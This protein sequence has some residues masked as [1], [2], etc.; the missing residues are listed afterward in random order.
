[1]IK[2]SRIA[3][4]QQVRVERYKDSPNHSHSLKESDM[5]KRPQA[6]RALVEHEAT[7]NYSP[8]AIVR[9][10]KEHA[11]DH[12]GLGESVTTLKRKEVYNVQHKFR[13]T[14]AHLVGSGVLGS[15]IQDTIQ[16]LKDKEYQVE[17]FHVS[18][19]S[20]EGIVLRIL[21]N[22]KNSGVLDG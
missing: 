18:Q 3:S 5:L 10:V 20:T 1:M 12:L 11:A 21:C 6:I 16:F 4:S 13:A 15:D 9:Y 7:K 17:H 2:I 22:S 8:P 14:N 19:R